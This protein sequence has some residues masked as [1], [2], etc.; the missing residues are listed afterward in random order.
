MS[1]VVAERWPELDVEA[2][3]ASGHIWVDGFPRKNPA[4][5]VERDA[6]IVLRTPQPLAGEAKLRAAL[7][8]F[9]PLVTDRVAIDIGA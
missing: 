9:A 1:T 5:L 2:A 4:M 3:I 7:E 8:A 6:S